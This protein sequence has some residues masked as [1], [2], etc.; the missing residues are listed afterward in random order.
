M[1]TPPHSPAPSQAAA[2]PVKDTE[3]G[4]TTPALGSHLPQDL[5]HDFIRQCSTYIP[6]FLLILTL[7]HHLV[8]F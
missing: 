8:F 6:P 4:V 2:S 1:R 5:P 7:P 3:A